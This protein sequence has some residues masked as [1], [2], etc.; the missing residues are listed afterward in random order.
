MNESLSIPA[1]VVILTSYV[2]IRL[3]PLQLVPTKAKA[4]LLEAQ[5][6]VWPRQ[7]LKI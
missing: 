7:K 1:G 6:H 2:A 4:S 5:F 3:T